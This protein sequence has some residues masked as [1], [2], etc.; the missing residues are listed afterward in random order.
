MTPNDLVARVRAGHRR[1]QALLADLTDSDV[2]AAS[3]L[4][5]WTRGHVITHLEQHAHAFA[6]QAD[7]ARRGLLVDVYDGGAP[8]RAAAIEREAGRGAEELRKAAAEAC[9]AIEDAWS[10]IGDDGWGAPVRYRDATLL[11]TV[12][13]RWREVEVHLVDLGLEYRPADWSIEFCD[14]LVDFLAPRVPAGTHL[15]LADDD[16]DRRWSIGDGD[17]VV[18]RGSASDL[19]AW[20]AERAP[21]RPVAAETGTPPEL[22]PWP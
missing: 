20:L 8:A 7:H 10:R 12:Y 5:G 16:A 11:D 17:P 13:A 15:T 14:H 18:L 2:R 22:G 6:R 3:P 21:A 9:A 19:S 4:P 1:L